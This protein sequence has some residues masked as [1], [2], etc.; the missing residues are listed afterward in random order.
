MTKHFNIFQPVPFIRI[1]LW[2]AAGVLCQ[3]VFSFSGTACGL[4]LFLF[5]GTLLYFLRKHDFRSVLVSNYLASVCLFLS[6]VWCAGQ[7]NRP[8][9]VL[10]SEKEY[11]KAVVLE[12]PT[13]KAR[14]FQTVLEISNPE[15]KISGK[16]I[17]YFGKDEKVDQLGPGK[18]I[19]FSARPEPIR[20][21]GNPYE[22]DYQGFMQRQGIG[23]SVYLRSN[24]YQLL[25]TT[26]STLFIWAENFRDRLLSIL[27]EH[28][29][30]GEEYTVVAA[31]TLGYRKEL[32]PVT[33]DYFASSGAMHVLAVSG[34]HVGI[35]YLLFAFLLS[36]LKRRRYGRMAYTVLVA[37]LIWL[38]A[39]LSGL[40]P[41]V[42]RAAVMFTFVLI[43]QNLNRPANIFNSLASSA[44]LLM[45]FNPQVIFEV[46]FQ[47]SYLAVS[48]IVLFQSVFYNL[49]E[50]KNRWL[51]KLWQLMT[52]SMA[53]QLATFPLGL[54]YFSQFPNYF[55]LSN[56]VVIPAATLILG[57]S[58]SLFLLSSISILADMAGFI[59]RQLTYLMLVSLKWMNSLPY[60]VVENISIT[61]L[62]A[63]SL[64][65]AIGFL[66]W[67]ICSKSVRELRLALLSVML[68]FLFAFLQNISLLNQQKMIVY[69]HPS[70]VIQ[71]IHGRS[72]YIVADSAKIEMGQLTRMVQNTGIHLKLGTPR[73]IWLGHGTEFTDSALIVRENFIWFSGKKIQLDVDG[74]PA[75]CSD[76]RIISNRSYKPELDKNSE[77][78]TIL[79][80]PFKLPIL[81]EI[82]IYPTWSEGAY[83]A[84]FKEN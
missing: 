12:K 14:S 27:R 2:F 64:L 22:F 41:S 71:F 4:V 6:G 32:S 11:Y 76:F 30:S 25:R 48:G 21:Q 60:A 47:L 36:P 61:P 78:T 52:V 18:Q 54:L 69:N 39:L 35:I 68:F 49:I 33:R 59:V 67:F 23:H 42:Q 17:A 13:E 40:S 77:Q 15:K 51:D 28:K 38:Y 81:C 58:F 44:F 1:T 73:Y 72:N 9:P 5:F 8:L 55:W 24:D 10:S 37:A 7:I 34:L 66:Y 63:L 57:A 3:N 56:F 46:G 65:A 50:V 83:I 75:F 20:N 45:L 43:G 79:T 70:P 19:V 31:L 80:R 26:R 82:N 84:N 74:P 53:A 16:V 29:I 62:Q